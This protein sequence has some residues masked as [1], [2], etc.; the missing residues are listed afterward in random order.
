MNDPIHGPA[1]HVGR[2]RAL[3]TPATLW[4]A[5]QVHV[6]AYS[7]VIVALIIGGVYLRVGN[8]RLTP[9]R[10]L[11]VV[12][13]FGLVVRTLLS[14]HVHLGGIA[15]RVLLA[16]LSLSLG[17]DLLRPY[18]SVLT[19][20][21]VSLASGVVWFYIVCGAKI[22]WG[23]LQR[24]INIVGSITGVVAAV[25][26]VAKL[27][28]FNPYGITA[29]LVVDVGSGFRLVMLT[30]EANIFGAIVAMMLV[31]TI[32]SLRPRSN[33]LKPIY[34]TFVLLLIALVGSLS[35]GPWLS[36][37]V[38]VSVYALLGS[39][40]RVAKR[41]F[42]CVGVSALIL[43]IVLFTSPIR[44]VDL[45]TRTH[46]IVVRLAEINAAFAEF[47]KHPV[48][49]NGTFSLSVFDPYVTRQF[50]S[51]EVWVGQTAVGVLSDTGIVGLLLFTFFLVALMG[52]AVNAIHRAHKCGAP[53]DA[54]DSAAVTVGM[55]AVLVTMGLAT[56]L[57]SLPIYWAI[58]GLVAR[59]PS[60][61]ASQGSDAY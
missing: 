19:V 54:V 46:N 18:S 51:T 4:R 35:K 50:G 47:A 25:A 61:L 60:L 15:G 1:P 59:V 23:H 27:I 31:S 32:P 56:T 43:S 9:A 55:G 30:W 13:F 58:M 22:H 42:F 3:A 40:G 44:T 52:R 16:W 2:L 53:H 11:G 38:G 17:V 5:K 8:A 49:G 14:Y 6:L 45:V 57:Y 26:L 28:A 33:R 37:I 21:W 10:A 29:R 36:F 41:I 7:L 12:L 48:L 34:M 20:H 39:S 24:A